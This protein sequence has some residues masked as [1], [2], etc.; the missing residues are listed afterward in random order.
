MILVLCSIRQQLLQN[1]VKM[2]IVHLAHWV[3][4]LPAVHDKFSYLSS[5]KLT[6]QRA[7]NSKPAWILFVYLAIV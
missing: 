1:P 2:Y 5:E 6:M 3:Q 7:V 4:R